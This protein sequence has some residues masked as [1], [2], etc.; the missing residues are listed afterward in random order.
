MWTV[1]LLGFCA[2]AAYWNKKAAAI[3]AFALCCAAA[4]TIASPPYTQVWFF[5]TYACVGAAV[6]FLLDWR[7]GALLCLV[8]LIGSAH[9][10]GLVDLLQRDIAG[11]VAFTVSL[12]AACVLGPSSGIANRGDGSNVGSGHSAVFRRAHGSSRPKKVVR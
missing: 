2:L 10:F 1:L 9:V 12:I 4:V 7:A 11:E 5:A 8:S 3:F 6:F